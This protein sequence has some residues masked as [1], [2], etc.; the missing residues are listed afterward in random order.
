M[1]QTIYHILKNDRNKMGNFAYS[2]SAYNLIRDSLY[3]NFIPIPDKILKMLRNEEDQRIVVDQFEQNN[4]AI[5]DLNSAHII[6][7]MDENGI[8]LF[9]WESMNKLLD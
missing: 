6:L 1:G 9:F 2:D 4:I 5:L 8:K 7:L 3:I